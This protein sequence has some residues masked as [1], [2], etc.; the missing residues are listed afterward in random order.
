MVTLAGALLILR[1]TAMLRGALLLALG[2]MRLGP[3]F[4]VLAEEAAGEELRLL[5]KRLAAVLRTMEEALLR[6]EGRSNASRSWLA[7]PPLR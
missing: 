3:A 2:A 1:L 7:R 6:S 5:D 4:V